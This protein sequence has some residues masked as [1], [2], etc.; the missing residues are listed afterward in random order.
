MNAE[1]VWQLLRYALLAAGGFLT[2]RGIL[3]DAAL[4]SVVGAI[5]LLFTTA[6]GVYIKWNTKSVPA[7][8]ADKPSVP[9]VSPVT[10]A[11]EK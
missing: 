11:V 4:E 6:W 3:A 7:A 1:I 10:G 5:G 2:S 8:V 9:T